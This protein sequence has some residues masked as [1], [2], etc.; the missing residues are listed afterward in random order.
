MATSLPPAAPAKVSVWEDVVDIF[1]SPVEVFVRRIGGDVW[2]PMGIL[3]LFSAVFYFAT[4]GL[5]QPIFDTEFARG[6]ARA[7]AKNP[8]IT[9]E[10]MEQGRA[11][12]QKVGGVFVIIGVP[13]SIAFVGIILWLV[14]KLFGA[15]ESVGDAM[16][17]ATYAWFPRIISMIVSA[18]IA[19]MVD[20]SKLNSM[21]SVTLSAGKFLDPD[22]TGHAMFLMAGRL[23]VFILWQTALLGLGL[24]VM[25]KIS[26][27]NGLIAAAIMWVVGS[28]MILAF[29]R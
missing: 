29:Q 17:I 27:A 22:T 13:I 5:M 28:G 11:M 10:Q 18:V 14:G 7:M 23:D 25:G 4:K 16:V 26:R 3:V 20:P 12:M 19:V 15:T 24:S 1:T 8:Q 2:I 9:A 6:A 21:F